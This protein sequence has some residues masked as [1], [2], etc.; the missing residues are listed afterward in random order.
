VVAV[1][2]PRTNTVIVSASRD[3]MLQISR[4]IGELDATSKKRQKVY[5]YSL[6]HADVNTVADILRGGFEEFSYGSQ[7]SNNNQQN[8]A[9]DTLNNRARNGANIGQ[10]P[11][12]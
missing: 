1:A 3:M 4:M 2:D 6:E 10:G 9:G 7:R 12:R 8:N 5:V 11:I